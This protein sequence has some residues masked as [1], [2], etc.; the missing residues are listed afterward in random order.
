MIPPG[1][2]VT[3]TREQNHQAALAAYAPRARGH[4]RSVA[5]ELAACRISSGKYAGG[6]GIE[7]RI[8]GR[9]IGELTHNMSQ[10]Y[11]PLV[12]E[13][14]A[15]SG[16]PGCE[17]VIHQGDR[18]IKTELRLLDPR[19]RQRQVQ[20]VCPASPSSSPVRPPVWSA[21]PPQPALPLPAL[22]RTGRFRIGWVAG[23]VVALLLMIGAL[24]DDDPQP[25][26][27]PAAASVAAPSTTTAQ[28]PPA[29]TDDADTGSRTRQATPQP[30]PTATPSTRRPDAEPR[31][32]TTRTPAASD[33]EP[34]SSRSDDECDPNYSGC[35]PVA[36]DVDCAGGS[37][38]GPAYV[39]GPVRVIGS[40]KYKLDRDGDGTAC[41]S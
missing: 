21:P 14:I 40:D 13:I 2:D 16:R 29:S 20:P 4:R 25:S 30:T 32:R 31:T 23:G 28:A 12:D 26:I 39:S 15:R 34:T 38:D 5:V 10:R 11:L 41:D 27:P 8:D 22:P 6:R 9:R 1:R 35:V 7:V 24:A 37:G 36:R 17:A 18:G 19:E 3:V 33:P